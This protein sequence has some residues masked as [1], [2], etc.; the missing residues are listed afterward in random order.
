MTEADV[1]PTGT[2]TLLFDS[3]RVNP[4]QEVT[5]PSLL[6]VVMLQKKQLLLLCGNLFPR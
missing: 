1:R 6:T 3:N 2:G 4:E 5:S